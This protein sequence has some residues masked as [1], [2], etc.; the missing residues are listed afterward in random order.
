MEALRDYLTRR[1]YVVVALIAAGYCALQFVYIAH[2]PLVMDEFDGAYE[3]FRLRHV[4][5][6]RD[7]TP[8]KTVLGYYL[9]TLGTFT[10][11]SVWARVIAMKAET[12][13]L[14]A[15]MLFSA[16]IALART[17]SRSAVGASLALVAVCSTFL[18][19]SSDLRVDMLT[20]WVGLW[21]LLALLRRRP[22]WAGFLAGLSFLV[23]Q[24]G[25]F[26]I[27]AGAI[28]LGIEWLVEKRN[29]EGFKVVVIYTA[30]CTAIITAYIVGWGAATTFRAVLSATFVGGVN[31]AA[32]NIYDI[33]ALFWKQVLSRDFA[34]FV[35][36]LAALWRAAR[37]DVLVFTYVSMVLVQ[38]LI[39]SQ[40]WPYFFVLLFPSLFVLIAI[41]LD[42]ARWRPHAAALVIAF[43]LVYPFR[44]IPV[45]L[46]RHNDYQRYNVDLAAGL[47][48]AGD[49]YLAGIEMVH[50]HEQRPPA[51][52]HLGASV[53]EDLKRQPTAV[54]EKITSDLDRN[55]PKLLI[56]NYR[57]YALR[58]PIRFYLRTH[59]DRVS[60]SVLLY[61]PFVSAGEARIAF[62]GTYRASGAVSV[63]GVPRAASEPFF[64]QPGIHRFD[65]TVRLRLFPAGLETLID[66]R[67]SG[68]Q[69]LFPAVYT[70]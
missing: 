70:Y 24:K 6:Y 38:A 41:F 27:L 47:L 2:L 10:A 7:F 63:D 68:E 44:R 42:Q 39:Y 33:R 40:P 69:D 45:V 13:I 67:Y 8:Y 12:A 15:A 16:A 32:V 35:V 51:L 20:G 49:K 1:F 46:H 26:Y 21:S 4:L 52:R 17:V 65:K 9:Q 61:A 53:V 18:E 29:R 66:P 56:G 34:Y 57:V 23:S 55:P 43:A 48:G 54:L 5:P 19:R 11:S 25:A 50:D 28:A 22:G 37:R 30:T 14:N 64:L 59:Y 58:G 31:A 3:A 36:A 62:G 60:G